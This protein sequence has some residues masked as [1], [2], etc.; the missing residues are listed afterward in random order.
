MFDPTILNLGPHASFIFAAY[1]VSFVAIAALIFVTLADDRKQRRMLA[2][3][4]ARGITRRSAAKPA[5]TPS[6]KVK[7]I[8]SN[9]GPNGKKAPA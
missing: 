9:E 7:E 2:E 1:A 6:P 3:L 5:R 8:G 4:E